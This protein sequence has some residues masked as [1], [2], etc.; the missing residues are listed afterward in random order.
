[1]ANN[2]TNDR[3]DPPSVSQPDFDP[4]RFNDM[5]IGEIFY[6]DQNFR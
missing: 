3:Y 6:L 5:P 2:P 4:I 1:M